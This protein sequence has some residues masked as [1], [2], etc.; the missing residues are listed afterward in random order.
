M[1]STRQLKIAKLLQKDLGVIFQKNIADIIGGFSMVTVTK[2]HVTKDLSQAKVYLSI[3]GTPDKAKVFNK[4]KA[5]TKTVRVYL[6]ERIKHQV[7]AIPELSFYN[8]DSLDY[9]EHIDDLLKKD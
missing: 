5:A 3:F 7:R 2:V 4:I 8:D 9:I 6:A 1:E